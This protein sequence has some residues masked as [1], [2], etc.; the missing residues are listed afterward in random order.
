LFVVEL[1]KTAFLCHVITEAI[2]P[3][4]EQ[5]DPSKNAMFLAYPFLLVSDLLSQSN[6]PH[7]RLNPSGHFSSFN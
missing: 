4:Q 3:A 1:D 2:S 6:L 5:L 7:L